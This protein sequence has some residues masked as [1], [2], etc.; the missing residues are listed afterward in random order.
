MLQQ[1]HPIPNGRNT[2]SST[3]LYLIL[4]LRLPRPLVACGFTLAAMAFLVLTMAPSCRGESPHSEAY[5]QSR[6]E[7]KSV[8]DSVSTSKSTV[9]RTKKAVDAVEAQIR[10]KIQQLQ[11]A[12]QPIP[13]SLK[14]AAAK[15]KNARMTLKRSQEVLATFG[16]YSEKITAV[17]DA[18]DKIVDLRNKMEADRK[19]MG[20]LAGELRALGTMMDEGGDYVPILGEALKA[21]G[22]VTTG[23]VDKLGQVANTIDSNRNQDQ[24]GRGTYDTN[25]RNRIF[26]DFQRAH[27][28]LIADVYSRSVPE[29]LYEPIGGPREGNSVLW[30][31]RSQ[32]F[33]I[34]PVDVPAKDI[35]KM[36]LL[37]DKRLSASDLQTLLGHWKENGAPKLK[38]SLALQSL[39]NDLRRGPFADVVSRVSRSN[40]GLLFRLLQNPELFIALYVYDPRTRDELNRNLQAIHDGLI[41]QGALDQAAKIRSFSTKHNLGLAFNVPGAAPLPKPDKQVKKTAEKNKPSPTGKTPAAQQEKQKEVTKT[42]EQ[43]KRQQKAVAESG[44]Q[45]N[46][47]DTSASAKKKVSAG[48]IDTCSNCAKNGLDCACGRAACRCC[49]PGDS[50]CNA[51]DL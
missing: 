26:R 40:D 24:I 15:F 23:L 37:L 14:D 7:F 20:N 31:E 42:G 18:Y 51:Y 38:T 45:K 49:A 47:N 41:A 39:L 35:F 25:E 3:F 46:K 9:E 50:N 4:A 16:N 17:T 43:E 13:D 30:D 19:A 1:K 33:V 2:P 48:S 29:Y 6:D 21:Y 28:E 5:E 11:K 36:T 12:N 44:V 22:A 32:Q 27:P 8:L 10:L 34:V